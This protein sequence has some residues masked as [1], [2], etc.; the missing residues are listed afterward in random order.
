MSALIDVVVAEDEGV[1]EDDVVPQVGNYSIV[2][3]GT[4]P[5]NA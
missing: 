5:G 4:Y 2:A 3:A 1:D